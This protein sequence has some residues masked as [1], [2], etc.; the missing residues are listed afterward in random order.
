MSKLVRSQ[1]PNNR[2]IGATIL[3]GTYSK[4]LYVKISYQLFRKLV[5]SENASLKLGADEFKLKPQQLESL[6]AMTKY[7]RE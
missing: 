4:F 6:R 7:V 5:D 3:T 1:P 2:I